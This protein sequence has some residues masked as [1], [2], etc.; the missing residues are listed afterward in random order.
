[1]TALEKVLGLSG[2]QAPETKSG[3]PAAVLVLAALADLEELRVLLAKPDD[4]DDD[5]KGSSDHSSH[6]TYKKLTGKGMNPKMAAS[7]CAR[8]DN[9]VKAAALT[10]AAVIALSGLTA[11][12]GNWVEATSGDSQAMALAAG[13]PFANVAY[14]DP[15]FRGRARF[16]VDTPEHT[17]ISWSFAQQDEHA[18]Q[19]SPDELDHIKNKIRLAMRKHGI[20]G[21]DAAEKVE[22]SYIVELAAKGKAGPAQNMRHGPFTGAHAHGHTAPSSA[23]EHDHFHNND[24]SHDFHSHGGDEKPDSGRD[25][26][27]MRDW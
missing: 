2:G 7:M 5:S 17:R 6:S 13:R 24:N 10:E 15:G 11:A 12:E 26:Y 14:A 18:R 9:R 4:G 20:K 25:S 21:G 3:D 1:M 8:A 19:Y 16:L 27:P 23:H 22:A